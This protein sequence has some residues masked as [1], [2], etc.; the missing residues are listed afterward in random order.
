M[1]LIVL[2]VGGKAFFV[3]NLLVVPVHFYVVALIGS[4]IKSLDTLSDFQNTKNNWVFAVKVIFMATMIF[5]NV[6]FIYFTYTR[7][8]QL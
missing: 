5:L 7:K 8:K 3:S 6:Y 1:F 2:E 4:N